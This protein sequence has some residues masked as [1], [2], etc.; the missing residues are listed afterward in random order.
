MSHRLD[1]RFAPRSFAFDEAK[2]QGST[3]GRRKGAVLDIVNDVETPSLTGS[4]T[5]CESPVCSVEF[6]PS[7]LEIKPKR[8]CSDQCKMNSWVIRRAA[9]LLEGIPIERVTEILRG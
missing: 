2:T 5:V 8:F 7:G 1:R 6:E 4:S 3:R 9:K